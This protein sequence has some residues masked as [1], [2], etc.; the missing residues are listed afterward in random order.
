MTSD[1]PVNYLCTRSSIMIG[2]YAEQIK[3]TTFYYGRKLQARFPKHGC[4]KIIFQI[5]TETLAFQIAKYAEVFQI[6]HQI[7]N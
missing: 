4:L 7:R 5:L 2:N 6:K 1:I 3:W